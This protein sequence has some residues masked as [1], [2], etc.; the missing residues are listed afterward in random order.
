[1]ETTTNNNAA[2]NANN[3]KMRVISY[4]EKAIAV[5]G[6]T[7]PHKDELKERGG[8]YNPRLQ[9]GAGWV[10]SRRKLGGTGLRALCAFVKKH[11]GKG[12]SKDA[13][14]FNNYILTNTNP[15]TQI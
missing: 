14:D 2:Q 5:I 15:A 9:C 4:S 8:R 3:N 7:K 12:L 11:G 1:M 6:D 10:F 13:L